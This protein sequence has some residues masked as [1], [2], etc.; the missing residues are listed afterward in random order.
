MKG[1]LRFG[2]KGKRSPWKV[3]PYRNPKR[4]GKVA[5]ELELQKELDAYNP[6]YHLSMFKK[7][8]SD[9]S[10]I[11][12][13]D[14]IEIKDNLS[15]EE[16]SVKILDRHVCKLRINKVGSIKILWR[17]QF[18]EEATSKA[19]EGMNKRYPHLF[20]SGKNANQSTNF[21]LSTIKF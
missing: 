9:P 16:I 19:E 2:K 17:N 10:L 8:M 6:V 3:R 18:V 7:C 4:I 13:T 15:N 11:I 14:T 20:E 1:V 12:P 5:Y 21:L